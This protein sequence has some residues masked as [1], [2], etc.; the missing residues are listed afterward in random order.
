[1]FTSDQIGG[2]VRA[3]LAAFGGVFIAKG[4][5]TADTW[6]WIVGGVATAIPAVWSWYTNKPAAL[7]AA[8]TK[9]AAAQ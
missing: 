2:L 3:A 9:I 7:I 6:S 1:M 4:Y 5:V 8:A